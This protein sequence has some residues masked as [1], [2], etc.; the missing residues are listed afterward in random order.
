MNLAEFRETLKGMR[1]DEFEELLDS[2][3]HRTHLYDIFRSAITDNLRAKVDR[4][5]LAIMRGIIKFCVNEWGTI[6]PDEWMAHAAQ[7]IGITGKHSHQCLSSARIF[8]PSQ[9][10]VARPYFEWV[11]AKMAHTKYEAWV[12]I[13]QRWIPADKAAGQPRNGIRTQIRTSAAEVPRRSTPAPLPSDAPRT[14]SWTPP[15]LG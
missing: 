11:V 5:K 14:L 7:V 9:E 8:K 6:P 10:A 3:T 2:G 4:K 13:E 15:T 12:R 1:Y